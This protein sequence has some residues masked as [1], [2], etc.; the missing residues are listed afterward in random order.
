MGGGSVEQVRYL[1]ESGCVEPL[2]GALRNANSRVTSAILDGVKNILDKGD[3]IKES[4][5]N[6]FVPLVRNAVHFNI[7]ER[8]ATEHEQGCEIAADIVNFCDGRPNST[9][10]SE[11]TTKETGTE[12]TGSFD[13]LPMMDE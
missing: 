11:N 2:I 7:I 4:S 6:P 5:A 12:D 3:L 8:V 10:Q 9:P 1:V 13:N